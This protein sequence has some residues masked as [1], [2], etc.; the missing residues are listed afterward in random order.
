MCQFSFYHTAIIELSVNCNP[1]ERP[2]LTLNKTN[3]GQ[4][5]AQQ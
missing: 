1:Q 2:Q 3:S 4:V 5:W